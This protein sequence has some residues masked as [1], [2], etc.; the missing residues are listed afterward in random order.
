MNECL[1]ALCLAFGTPDGRL[2]VPL[3]TEAE[4]SHIAVPAGAWTTG[5]EA[6]VAIDTVPR[7]RALPERPAGPPDRLFGEDKWKHFFTSFVIT[8]LG[9]TGARAAGLEREWSLGVGA[10]L[11]LSAGAAKEYAD[12]R[13]PARGNPSALDLVWDV[14]GTGA[15]VVVAA[16]AY[17]R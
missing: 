9:A 15:G 1:L 14:L 6:A 10:G 16:Q 8:S 2:A 12:F 4:A 3:P 11:S 13:N 17:P 5:V 7:P